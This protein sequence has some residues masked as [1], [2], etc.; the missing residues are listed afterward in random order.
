MSAQTFEQ[1]INLLRSDWMLL[2][3]LGVDMDC[4]HG[5]IVCPF[6]DDSVGSLSV[7]MDDAGIWRWTC[8]AGCGTGTY[9]DAQRRRGI[10]SDL[11]IE[12]MNELLQ[13]RKRDRK[14]MVPVP[15]K[16]LIDN[17]LGGGLESY[18]ADALART[19]RITRQ[20]ADHY[21]L[22]TDTEYWLIPIFHPEKD[23]ICAV[24]MHA[25]YSETVPKSK[26]MACGTVPAERPK[27]GIATLYPRPEWWNP[28]LRLFILPGELKAL[29]MISLGHQAVSPT[30]GESFSW[31][32]RE[33]KRL[34]GFRCCVVYD[35]D[36]AG[37]AFRYRTMQKLR[38]GGIPCTSVT[39]GKRKPKAGN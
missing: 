8:H 11:P 22:S 26:W 5:H 24:K 33:L 18:D 29:R 7:W 15:N 12:L 3:A 9:I 37:E 1:V 17:K 10:P 14:V 4:D 38:N 13:T 19:R 6:H 25:M 21:Y 39:A 27:H 30:S 35:D 16:D 32:E 34:K 31:P 20:V 23:D 36:P 2:Q 28:L